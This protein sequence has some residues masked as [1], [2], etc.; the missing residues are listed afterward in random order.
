[1]AEEEKMSRQDF[2]IAYNGEFRKDINTMDVG[3]L[4]PAMM[5]L[6]KLMR[7]ANLT[8]NGKKAKANVLVSSDFEHKC[9]YISFELIVTY[10]EQLKTF[11]GDDNVQTAKDILEWIGMI[12]AGSGG[13]IGFLKYLE[14]RK[15]RKIIDVIENSDT[16]SSGT[17]QVK[18]EGEGNHITINQN[19][20][21]LSQDTKALKNTR[22]ALSPIGQD[23]IDSIQIHSPDGKLIDKIDYEQV[24]GVLA[25]C[26]L[27]IEEATDI[28]PDV[29]E[30]T[31]WLQVYSPVYEESAERWRFYFGKEVIYA[32]I[33]ETEIS[34]ETL[35][36]G[37][38]STD[39]TYQVRLEI[40]TPFDSKGKPKKSS[41]RVLKVI[42]FIP[43]EHSPEQLNMLMLDDK[44]SKKE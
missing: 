39:D 35:E 15:G 12:G 10:Y 4:A 32:D 31:A 25:S 44:D 23:G 13:T 19:V 24:E 11:L 2:A 36:R 7:Q 37:V 14:W 22:D 16:D 20:Y 41:Y 17:V 40:T 21:K 42:R 18:F 26:N 34:K 27:G 29:E 43:G 9:F 8:A 3:Q 5:A 30:T 28:E 6:G 33:S 38:T 1:M